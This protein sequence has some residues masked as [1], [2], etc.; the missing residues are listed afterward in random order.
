MNIFDNRALWNW[1]AE[2]LHRLFESLT[3]LRLLDCFQR[4]SEQF[5]AVLCENSL[6]GKLHGE[7]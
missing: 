1:F 6:L 2:F 7:V 4:S 5:H 3:I